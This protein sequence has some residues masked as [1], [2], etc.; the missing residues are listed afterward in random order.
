MNRPICR[1]G[2]QYP[3]VDALG[4]SLGFD[5]WSERSWHERAVS[6][7]RGTCALVIGAAL[8]AGGWIGTTVP[9]SSILERV[10]EFVL[11]TGKTV[12]LA[13]KL[14]PTAPDAPAT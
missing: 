10:I 4:V 5:M 2:R 14:G 7:H 8:V 3:V 13:V 12:T 1:S 11:E 6:R 9:Q